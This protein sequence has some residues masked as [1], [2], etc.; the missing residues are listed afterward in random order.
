MGKS[1]PEGYEIRGAEANQTEAVLDYLEVVMNAPREYFACIYRNFPGDVPAHSRIALA[2]GRI[3]AHVH[4][5]PIDFW[6]N[7]VRVPGM[8]IGDVSTHPDHRRKGLGT[9]LLQ[10]ACRHGCEAHGATF[11]LL[12]SGVAHFY[13]AAGWDVLP[14]TSWRIDVAGF[15]VRAE[16]ARLDETAAEAMK[17]YQVRRFERAE[18]LGRIA[19]I[20]EE[21]NRGRSLTVIRS[22]DYWRRHFY[23][24]SHHEVESLFLVAEMNG[25]VV[26]YSRAN[27]GRLTEM[28]CLPEHAPAAFA[29]LESTI[30]QLRKR[31]AGS[32]QVLVPEDHGLWALLSASENAEA[33]EHRGH[34]LRQ[35]DWAGML[36][37]FEVAFRE[38]A[39]RAGIEPARPVTLSMGAQTVTLPLPSASEDAATTCDLEL[40]QIDAFR[41]VTGAVRGSSLT[42]D[43]ELGKLLDSLFE[44]DSPIF[45]PMDVV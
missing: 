10:D 14:M 17:R 7:G 9:L 39:K 4:A 18:E 32:F 28:G 43:A 40:N 33:A 35:I 34:W 16:V 42:D 30:R 36:A 20:H 1:L 19:N 21:Q 23:W 26:A 27:A 24:S 12:K 41:L 37:Y 15:D 3:V 8:M 44:E 5:F 45:W 6:M 11:A 29:L 31:D 38:R 13:S 2:D 22:W 25:S